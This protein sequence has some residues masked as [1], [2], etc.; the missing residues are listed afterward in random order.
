MTEIEKLRKTFEEKINNI[1][2]LVAGKIDEKLKS[3]NIDYLKSTMDKCYRFAEGNVYF[4]EKCSDF[5]YNF[6]D[7]YYLVI[8]C[9]EVY[10]AEEESYS[11][12]RSIFAFLEYF[13]ELKS[14]IWDIHGIK[15]QVVSA[16]EIDW[17]KNKYELGKFKEIVDTFWKEYMDVLSK[18]YIPFVVELLPSE[19]M[20]VATEYIYRSVYR[21]EKPGDKFLTLL[22]QFQ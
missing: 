10:V 12:I 18:V 17:I 11:E 3:L 15:Y 6:Q 22:K 7:R 14:L 21:P 5:I 19:E 8:T 20:K 4:C 9:G 2:S 16:I 13:P 1:H